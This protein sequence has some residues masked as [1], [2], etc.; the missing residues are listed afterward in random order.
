MRRAF[1]LVLALAA[2]PLAAAPE[3]TYYPAAKVALP[4][5]GVPLGV[6][7]VG[8]GEAY[9][10]VAEDA[11]SLHWNPAGL[12]RLNGFQLALMHNEWAGEMG[13]R[14]EY[15]AYGMSLGEKAG[16][17]FSFNY[18]SLGTLEARSE[19]GALGAESAAAALAGSLGYATSLLAGDR[20]KL[21]VAADFGQESLFGTG[22]SAFGGSLGLLYQATPGFS[23]GLSALRLGAAAGGFSP[24]SQANLGAAY[25][26][27]DRVAVLALDG[28][29]PLA[30]DPAVK[31][32]VELNL[33]PMALRGGWRQ[34][35]GAPEGAVRGGFTAGAGFRSGVF[36]LDYAF[37]PNG[38]LGSAH[39][40]A[41]SVDLPADFFKP[42]I[43]AAEASTVTARSHYDKAVAEE[44]RNNLLQALV[45]YQRA[46]DAYPEDLV[47]QKK[48]QP[49]Y[50]A[51]VAKI[52]SIQKEMQKSGGNEQVRRLVDKAIQDGRALLEQRKFRD[53][54]RKA[55]EAQA[56]EP[57]NRAARE[58]LDEAQA[59]LRRRKRE[60]LAQGEAAYDA[61]KL[62]EAIQRHREV[63]AL[64]E[65][66]EQALAF[67]N[68]RKAQINDHLRSI[69]R[70]G[71]DLYVSGRIRD[72]IRVWKEGRALDRDGAVNFSRDI[73]KAEKV[74][75]VRGTK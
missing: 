68:N 63:L 57:N 65:T 14:Q 47:K 16:L 72:A 55:R 21:G 58:L 59:G 29:L 43:V 44:K 70:R 11:S 42:K 6:R 30:G 20:L 7:A 3:I 67:F 19:D 22:S 37:A 54:M 48:A 71:I 51:A 15:L 74:L 17:G 46:K 12:A 26:F 4:T 34:L 24:P 1:G 28:A 18:F 62:S 60:L 32:G 66:D 9:T 61:N 52:A 50:N 56:L 33:G 41:V 13:L 38:S 75:E 35:L 40:V 25:A 39:R 69:H 53:A 49:F 23:L 36:G 31:A 73:E 64:D 10:A 8:L 45:E 5:L 27:K 2:T